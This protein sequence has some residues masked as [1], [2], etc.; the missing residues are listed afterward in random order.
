MKLITRGRL[1]DLIEEGVSIEEHHCSHRSALRQFRFEQRCLHSQASTR[2]LDVNTR[3]R[4]V[5][6]Q[7]ERQTHNT[8]VADRSD[9]GRL[10][11]RHGVHQGAD[12]S[13][14]E[15]DKTDGDVYKRQAMK[16]KDPGLSVVNSSSKF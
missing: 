5:V 3:G 16:G 15:I 10:P 8:F 6:A 12:A 2:N 11:V 9:L 13:L 7:H 14:D 4:P 1:R